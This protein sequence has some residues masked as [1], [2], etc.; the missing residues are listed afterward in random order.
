MK[1]FIYNFTVE[2]FS[3]TPLSDNESQTTC[4]PLT[5]ICCV[6]GAS[7][8]GQLA[9]SVS[10]RLTWGEN[11]MVHQHLKKTGKPDLSGPTWDND[12]TA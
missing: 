5:L 9:V 11:R 10:L 1:Y 6:G 3:E 2:G 12:Y 4:M 8:E 7:S